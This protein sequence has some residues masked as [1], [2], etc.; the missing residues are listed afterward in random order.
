MKKLL[1]CVLSVLGVLGATM[2]L[3]SSEKEK[4]LSRLAEVP[5]PTEAQEVATFGAGCFWCVEAVL[6]KIEGVHHV[7]SGYMGG[8]VKNPAY[9]EVCEGTTGHAE[10]TQVV[11]DPKKVS[12]ATLLEWFW[13][14]HDPT[15]K[16]RQGNDVGTQY[17]SV[18][19]FH[20]PEQEKIA[21]TSLAEAQKAHVRPIV[22]EISPAVEFYPAENYHQ[23]YYQ[24]NKNKN[25]YC[26][27]V[28]T[29][30]MKKLGLE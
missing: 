4:E 23:G 9:R 5:K 30:K 26:P 12:Y 29:P 2:S 8:H 14:L 11:F 27:A 18:I 7:T 1:W 17:R 24:L 21:Q 15:Q 19:F 10:V 22:T 13:K 20:S 28:I 3:W 25:P 16:N 6:E